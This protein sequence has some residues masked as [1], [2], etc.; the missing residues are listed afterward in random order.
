[1]PSHTNFEQLY[2]FLKKRKYPFRDQRVSQIK[3]CIDLRQNNSERPVD[4]L[5]SEDYLWNLLLCLYRLTLVEKFMSQRS[6]GRDIPSKWYD[7]CYLSISSPFHIF[8]ICMIFPVSAFHLFVCH[9][10]SSFGLSPSLNLFFHQ[11]LSDVLK[12]IDL[13][14][15]KFT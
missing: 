2:L 11:V 5:V 10:A 14:R 15:K 4:A 6:H 1:M 12:E 9:V 3:H 8:C 7:F 13:R